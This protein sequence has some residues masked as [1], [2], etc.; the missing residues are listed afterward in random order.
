MNINFY[1]NI[2]NKKN[3]TIIV[4]SKPLDLFNVNKFPLL[5]KDIILNLKNV[6]NISSK[7]E[8]NKIIKLNI[9]VNNEIIDLI[10][11]KADNFLK[12]KAQLDGS[13]IYKNISDSKYEEVNVIFSRAAPPP[14][15]L[16]FDI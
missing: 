13:I 5:L 3:P 4:V 11:I 7:L 12:Y 2:T 6:R 14:C 16:V 10:I 9:V 15:L 1:N 8:N